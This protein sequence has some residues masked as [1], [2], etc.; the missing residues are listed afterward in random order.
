MFIRRIEDG[1]F[2]INVIFNYHH[3][4]SGC[5]DERQYE[6]MAR[7]SRINGASSVSSSFLYHIPKVLNHHYLSYTLKWLPTYD[8]NF[9]FRLDGLSLFFSLLISIIGVAVFFYATQYL[10]HKYDD[11]PRFY[12]YLVLFMFSMLGIVL[13]NNT[14]ILYIFWELTSVSSF[15]LISYWYDKTDSQRGQ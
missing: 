2:R 8:I 11:L 13:A 5:Y 10:S 12:I 9:D 3:A 15:L 6:T 7:I 1:Y 4:R 14:I